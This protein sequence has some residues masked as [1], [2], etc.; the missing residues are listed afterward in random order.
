MSSSEES[1]SETEESNGFNDDHSENEAE[2]VEVI[3]P[4]PFIGPLPEVGANLHPVLKRKLD[5]IEDRGKKAAEIQNYKTLNEF[6]LDRAVTRAMNAELL[7]ALSLAQPANAEGSSSGSRAPVLPASSSIT[8][9]ATT[10][11]LTR[12]SRANAEQQ[13]AATSAE[14]VEHSIEDMVTLED[15]GTTH[16]GGS[17]PVDWEVKATTEIDLASVP[18]WLMAFYTRF[19]EHKGVELNEIEQSILDATLT[20]WLYLESLFK[21]A[22]PVSLSFVR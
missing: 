3:H 5:A 19:S 11:P 7:S 8:A 14:E 1:A 13:A 21:F 2:S 16:E 22:S 17:D 9:P 18:A 4:E 12:S 20:D 15:V 10:P 6:E